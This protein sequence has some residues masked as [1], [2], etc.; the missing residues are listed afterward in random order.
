MGKTVKSPSGAHKP[1]PWSRAACQETVSG[2]KSKIL[3]TNCVLGYGTPLPPSREM[4][5]QKQSPWEAGVPPSHLPKMGYIT[6]HAALAPPHLSQ[7]VD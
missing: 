1:G 5:D 7:K 6:R 4:T 3:A 2:A